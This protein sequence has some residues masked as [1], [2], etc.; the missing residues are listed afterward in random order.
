MDEVMNRDI[1]R[2]QEIRLNILE[3]LA[4][5][6]QALALIA[7]TISEAYTAVRPAAEHEQTAHELAVLARYQI[8]L[9]EQIMQL[10]LRNT[11]LG[12]PV[13][14]WLHR[15]VCPA[16]LCGE[17]MPDSTPHPFGEDTRDFPAWPPSGNK[18]STAH[19]PHLS[20]LIFIVNGKR[21][22]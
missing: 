3:S 18:S 9:A 1:L 4:R 17:D 6:Q 10:R 2:E 20:K 19:P 8:R 16:A 15:C 11:R 12:T 14:P 22:R 7:E 21:D 13:R 5:S